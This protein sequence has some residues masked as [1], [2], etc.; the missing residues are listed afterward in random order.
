MFTKENQIVRDEHGRTIRKHCAKCGRANLVC[1]YYLIDDVWYCEPCRDEIRL[2][3]KAK[4]RKQKWDE[5]Y[6]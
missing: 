4:L 6:G 1:T 2:D 3:E 5:Y